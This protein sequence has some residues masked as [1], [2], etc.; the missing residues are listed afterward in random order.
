[1]PEQK[2]IAG[3]PENGGAITGL[4]GKINEKLEPWVLSPKKSQLQQPAAALDEYDGGEN[5]HLANQKKI[6]PNNWIWSEKNGHRRN[7]RTA[8]VSKW[9][10][11]IL[12]YKWTPV[13]SNHKCWQ[14]GLSDRRE[15]STTT[16][17]RQGWLD[18]GA[19]SRQKKTVVS[20]D[21]YWAFDSEHNCTIG[22]ISSEK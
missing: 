2:S 20:N 22:I 14:K 18:L 17:W 10:K 4:L 11:F 21:T 16:D 15:G 13:F 19:G 12:T 8:T 7:I 1:M 6:P 9:S 5:S 3:P